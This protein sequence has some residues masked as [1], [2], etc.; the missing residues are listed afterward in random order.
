MAA[1][2]VMR[3]TIERRAMRKS[4]IVV[5][6]AALTS[7]CLTTRAQ[8]PIERQA[9]DVPPAP[10]RVVDPAPPPEPPPPEPVPELP[11]EK[12]VPLPKPR[13]ASPREK[14]AESAKPDPK[15][16]LTPVE[17]PPFT[18]P[19]TPTL[20]NSA[21]AD[22]AAAER[23]IR[24]SL[25]RTLGILNNIDYRRLRDELKAAYDQAKDHV[26]TAETHLKAQGFDLA[27]E[28]ADKAE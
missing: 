15:A 22:A 5:V 27:K 4:A 1:C 28:L 19:P 12:I 21:T 23:R 24:E 6:L 10:P 14:P 11:P 17:P 2:R 8:V 9:L 26:N 20:R 16:E 18:T 25:D 7:G 13:P 3:G